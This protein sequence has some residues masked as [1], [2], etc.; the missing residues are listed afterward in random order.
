MFIEYDGRKFSGWQK[1]PGTR[2]VQS[3]I[4]KAAR[5]LFGPKITCAAAGRTDKGVHALSQAVSL[6][7]DSRQRDARKTKELLKRAAYSLNALLPEDISVSSVQCVDPGFTPRY[8]A[9]SKVY[10]YNI[11]NKPERSV[12]RSRTHWHLPRKLDI[13]LMKKACGK[14]RGRHDFSSFDSAGS[15]HKNKVVHV[16]GIGIKKRGPDIEIVF[17]ADR[18]LYKMIRN[19]VG[20][21]AEVGRGGLSPGKVAEILAARNRT[22]TYK[23]AP[24][25]GLFLEK[26]VF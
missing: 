2:T 13:A 18:Y 24:A 7:I 16:E 25:H 11:W 9:K 22:V 14:L 1:Q 15:T 10:K 26:V 17:K 12:W 5:K 23:P 19:I 4:E 21:L 6:K 8:R 3:E 20:C